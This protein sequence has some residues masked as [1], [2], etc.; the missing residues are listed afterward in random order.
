MT[1]TCRQINVK[2]QHYKRKMQDLFPFNNTDFLN[3]VFIVDCKYVSHLVLV[4]LL[5]ALEIN[6]FSRLCHLLIGFRFEH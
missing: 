6:L 1:N 3:R 4:A 5:L 2:S